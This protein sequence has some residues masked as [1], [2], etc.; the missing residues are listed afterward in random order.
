VRR[1]AVVRVGPFRYR[2]RFIEGLRTEVAWLDTKRRVAYVATDETP[3]SQA[4]A[5]LHELLHAA[6][7]LTPM[8]GGAIEEGVKEEA[9]VAGLSPV[10]L[11]ILRDNPTLVAFLVSAK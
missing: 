4:E 2:V 5:L 11:A 6:V 3:E 10:L 7:D 8:R 9:L 1:P